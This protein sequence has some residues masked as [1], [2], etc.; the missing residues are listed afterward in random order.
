MFFYL[1]S[2]NRCHPNYVSTLLKKDD[3]SISNL[4]KVLSRIEPE[5]KKLL[6]DKDIAEELYSEFEKEIDD[7]EDYRRLS[8]ELKNRNILIIGPGK[9]VDL[10][11]QNISDYINA[12][13]P[14]IISINYIPDGRFLQETRLFQDGTLLITGL[15]PLR[16]T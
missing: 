3:L 11:R 10:Q 4:D 15:S 7:T 1:C 2:K 5:P 14:V 16:H 13:N 8:E 9:N 6:Y 12:N